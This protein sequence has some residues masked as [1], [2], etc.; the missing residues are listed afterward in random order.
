MVNPAAMK[1]QHHGRL[2]PETRKPCLIPLWHLWE[3]MMRKILKKTLKDMNTLNKNLDLRRRWKNQSLQI[4]YL[5]L[6]KK[7]ILK[8]I[9][10]PL[11]LLKKPPF[12]KKRKCLR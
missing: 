7:K 10:Q 2:Y 3:T 8:L 11:L 4:I 1:L 6:R 12:Q 5:W 9:T